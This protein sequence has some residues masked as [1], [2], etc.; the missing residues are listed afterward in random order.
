MSSSNT[1]PEGIDEDAELLVELG[2][3]HQIEELDAIIKQYDLKLE[4]AFAPQDGAVTDLDDYYTVNIPTARTAAYTDIVAA[5]QNSG[6]VDN[7][8]ANEILSLDPMETKPNSTPPQE[9]EYSVDDP[10]LSKVWGFRAM[11]IQQLYD[12]LASN[13]IKPKKKAKIA[14]IDTGVDKDHE[15]LKANFVSTRAIHNQD[16]QGHGTHCAGIA[17]AVSNNGVG[18]ASFAP[19]GSYVEVTSIKVFGKYGSTSQKKIIDGMIEA[20]DNGA[21]VL[22]MS[23]GGPSSD[24]IQRAYQ[25]AVKYANK[26]G[27]IVVVAAGNENVNA[28]RRAPA[29]VDGVITVSAIDESIQK[30]GFSNT[31]GDL[32]MGIA[33]P[34]AQIYSTIPNNAYEYFNGTSMATPYVAGLVGLLKS[35]KPKLTTK[36]VYKILNHTGKKTKQTTKTGKLIYPAGAVKELLK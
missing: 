22:S 9:G 8:E 36:E 28:I 30:A 11:E 35:I 31:V 5:L 27:A 15:D 19:N 21:A 10:E 25:Q 14:I 13:K 26:K 2:N 23:L 17:A 20:A 33:A 16:P 6:L 7:V 1:L 18:V 3:G 32:K 34:G 24:K 29:S 12:Y 4:R